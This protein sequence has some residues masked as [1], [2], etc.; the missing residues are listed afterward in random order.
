MPSLKLRGF[1][2]FAGLSLI[3]AGASLAA[4]PASPQATEPSPPQAAPVRP[5]TND[6]FGVKVE[7]PYQY[8]ENTKDPEVQA[9]FKAQNDYTRAILAAIPNRKALLERI[10]QLDEA[11]PAKVNS[12][13]RLAT[14]RYFYLKT[15]PQDIQAKM[16][17]RDGLTGKETLLVDTQKFMHAGGPPYA[18]NYF[19]PSYDG[20]YVAY[21]VSPGGSEDAVMHVLDTTS[22]RDTGEAIDRAQFGEATSWLPGESSFVYNRLQKLGPGM[23]PTARY[24]DSRVFLHVVGTDPEKDVPVFGT[25]LSSATA[26]A[27][28]DIPF[29]GAEPG[30][31]Y[32]LGIVA[33]GV[34]REFTIYAATLATVAKGHP[35]WKKVCDVDDDVTDFSLHGTT[36]YLLT[37]KNAPRFKLIRTDLARPDSAHAAEVLPEGDAVLT[38]TAT[39]RDALYVHELDGG[40]GRIV[41]V[42]YTGGPPE[43]L[44]LPFDGSVNFY[45]TDPRMA[46]I[47][48]A[49]TSWVKGPRIYAYD[50]KTGKVT[51]TGLRPAGPYDNPPDLTSVEVKAR[52]YDGTMVPLS[53]VYKRGLKMDG[54]NPAILIGY[55][56]YGIT[57]DPFFDAKYLAWLERGGVLAIAHIRGGGE[58]GEDWHRWGQKLTKANTWRDFIASAEYLIEHKYTSSA[59]LAGLGGSAGGIT[60]GRSITE[61]PELFGAA[62]IQVGAL[63]MLRMETTPNGVPNVPEFGSVKTEEGFEDLYR[64]SAYAHVR[65]GTAYPAVLLTTGMNDPRV[66]PWEPAKMA[67]RLEAATTSGK[68]ILL[69]VD[70]E[71]GHGFGSTKTQQQELI[72]DVFSFCFRQ[73]TGPAQ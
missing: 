21:G 40:I 7:D 34:R 47:V 8:F 6:Y 10:K 46:G 29:V 2:A 38:G 50:P 60:V 33:H 41:R 3:L 32:A 36:I 9:W 19:S 56:S 22:G 69:R 39:A 72:G 27:A 18:I 52:S 65:K 11:A 28:T 62:V 59:H 16:Y 54:S 70:Y 31:P 24:L 64:M 45:P 12:V 61:R 49:M 66:E 15:L 53:I 30:S 4:G 55:G 63:D 35:E 1:L 48:F 57:I 44:A 73:L 68:P 51:D 71:A 23:P 20:R 26:V 14:G 13:F 42:P 25:G 43:T 17:M 5:V 37:H 67:A 58:Y